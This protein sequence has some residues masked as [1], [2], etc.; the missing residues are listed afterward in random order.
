MS[1]LHAERAHGHWPLAAL[2]YLA[3]VSA[4]SIAYYA[5]ALAALSLYDANATAFIWFPSA[6]PL[7]VLI[8]YGLRY[9]PALVFG[10]IAIMATRSLAIRADIILVA[11]TVL[12]TCAG[13]FLLTRVVR[14]RPQFER[15]RDV[16]IFAA[17]AFLIN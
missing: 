11:C 3:G 9:W 2:R 1:V 10:S 14:F 8:L 15:V 13:A 12:E 7:A 4:L 5:S 17:V 6:I 16:L